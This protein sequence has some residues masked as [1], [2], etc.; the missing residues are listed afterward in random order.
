L[1]RASIELTNRV[2]R[3]SILDQDGR[4]D[5]ALDPRLSTAEVKRLFHGLLL[6]RRLDERLLRLQRQG[7]IG[8]FGPAL[9]QEAAS[10]G[11]AFV[12]E[13]IDWL[14]PSFREPAA[15]LW[16]GWPIEKIILWWAGH[17]VGATVPKEVNDLP[18]CVPVSTQCL[19][20]AGIAWGCKLKKDGAV[21]VCFTGDGGTSE[22]D[23]HEA[24][25][26]AAVHVLPVVFIIQN[27]HWAI[28]LP[29]ERQSK[30]ATLAQKCIAYGM[31]GI[32]A[33][34]NDLLAMVVAAREAID[35]ARSGQG[36]TLI[37]AVTYRL[38]VHTTADDPKK[39]R[40]EQEVAPWTP[41]DPLARFQKYALAREAVDAPAIERMDAEIAD[42]IEAAVQEA[43]RYVPDPAESFRNTFAEMTPAL[44]E[45]LRE[46]EAEIEAARAEAGKPEAPAGSEAARQMADA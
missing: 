6:S 44:R 25:N 31:D 34:G 7:R 30:C 27:N 18:I 4:V 28:S 36:P 2:E 40:T 37:E 42:Q 23:F 20:A 38:G 10:L 26:F 35:R 19:H 11:P 8:T 15:M 22:G 21:V 43:E 17:E 45:Q 3:L 1:P 46:M 32:Q 16:R 33:D 41:R 5:A 13:Q 29:R 9:G 39:Y 12:M 24:L 14:V